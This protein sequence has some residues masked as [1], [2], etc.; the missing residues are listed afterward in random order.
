MNRRGGGGGREQSLWIGETDG[1]KRDGTGEMESWKKNAHYVR[2]SP[3]MPKF[4][5]AEISN[6]CD[7]TCDFYANFEQIQR[8]FSEV[9][10][11]GILREG[12]NLN[13]WGG[14]PIAIT[15]FALN[16]CKNLWVHI[17]F[18]T[19]GPHK[20]K[21]NQWL[22]PVRA[23]PQLLRNPRDSATILRSTPRFQIAQWY[24]DLEDRNLVKLRSLDPSCP[25]CLSDNSIWGQWNQMLQMLG[26][27]G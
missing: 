26:S 27:Q 6:R 8:R 25:F 3:E 23:P 18:N 15:N 12:G 9:S 10:K 22:Q 16:P 17:G 21:K 20:K 24:C 7:F 4:E 5:I 1:Q 13:N 11:G 19:A 14:A 2:L